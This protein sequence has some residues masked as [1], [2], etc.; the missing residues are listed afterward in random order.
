MRKGFVIFLALLLAMTFGVFASGGEEGS[1]SSG[2]AGGGKLASYMPD[3]DKK[4]SLTLT[5]QGGTAVPQDEN[6]VMVGYWEDKFNVDINMIDITGLG[7]DAGT[8]KLNLMITSGDIPDQFIANAQNLQKYYETGILAPIDDDVAKAYMPSIMKKLDEESNGTAFDHGKFEGTRYGLIRGF[9]WPAQFR[10]DFIVRGD[11]LKNLGLDPPKTLDEYEEVFYAFAKND[12]DGNG[13]DDTYGLSQQTLNAMYGAFGTVL[14]QWSDIDGKV[15]CDDIQPGMKEALR[16]LSKW[17]A[18]GVLDPEFITGENQGGYW[19]VTHAFHAGRIGMTSMGNVYHWTPP[20]PGRSE[21]ANFQEADKV[22]I[23]DDL[24]FLEPPIGPGG[25]QAAATQGEL[26][27]NSF[28]IYGQQLNDEPDK[29][30]KLME[31]AEYMFNGDKDTFLTVFMGKKDTHWEYDAAGFPKFIG[32]MNARDAQKLGAWGSFLW[33]QFI[34]ESKVTDG[35]VMKF[36]EAR[37]YTVGLKGTKVPGFIN[38]P[39]RSQYQAELNKIRDEAFTAIILGNEPID[40]FDTY[41]EK[42]KKSGGDQLTKEL[43]EWY[44]TL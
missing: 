6:A 44:S 30:G 25:K 39:A 8:Q 42:W 16:Y 13:K 17:Y 35:S 3:P 22:G 1:T 38:P 18:D 12:P 34:N 20:L 43:N 27:S 21:G 5:V 4:Y 41:V 10:D 40:Y 11:W 36:A 32:E 33:F 23:Y 26:M 2:S 9:W 7:G 14:G 28:L 15:A 31:M 37:N 24:I 29:M 19:A